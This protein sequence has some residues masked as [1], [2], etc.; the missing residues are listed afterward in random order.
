MAKKQG[1][2]RGRRWPSL[3]CA[4]LLVGSAFANNAIPKPMYSY[5]AKIP[6]ECLDRSMLVKHELERGMS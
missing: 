5:G 2:Q 6:V 1:R 4:G 3:I